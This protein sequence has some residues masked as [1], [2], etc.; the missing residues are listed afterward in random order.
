MPIT[1]PCQNFLK[2]GKIDYTEIDKRVA[3]YHEGMIN[4][5]LANLQII[6]GQ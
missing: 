3:F 5:V 4:N 2:T 1:K 6:T